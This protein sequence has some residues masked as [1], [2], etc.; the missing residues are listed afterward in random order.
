VV[1]AG[2]KWWRFKYRFAGKEK[3]LSFGTYPD[4][5]LKDAREKRDQTRKLLA[6][7]IDPGAHRKAHKA[8]RA[9][10]DA[11]SFETVAREWFSKFAPKWA[12]S[13]SSKILSR[14]E[15]DIFPWLGK[16]PIAELTAP[17][18]L[19]A[20]RRIEHRGAVETAHRALQNVSQVFRYAIASGRAT[21]DL[22]PG[23]RGA[24]PPSTPTHMRRSPIRLRSAPCCASSMAMQDRT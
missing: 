15:R 2:G 3:L 13:H 12:N 10:T 16:R 9:A 17:E 21:V 7:D 24:L 18:L 4:V 6:A 19:S 11:D 1:P 5:S 22:T 14:L 20:L 23:L 8:A